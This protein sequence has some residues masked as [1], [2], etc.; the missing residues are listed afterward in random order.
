[1][2]RLLYLAWLV[3]LT[4]LASGC[5]MCCAPFDCDYPY[6]GGRWVRHN[7]SS[8][9]VGSAFDEAGGPVDVAAV[10]AQEPTPARPPG[11]AAPPASPRVQ[12]VIPRNMGESYLPTTP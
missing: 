3:S 10:S 1:M 12:S 2:R 7:P 8:G 4:S 11:A 5:A 6:L 9:R